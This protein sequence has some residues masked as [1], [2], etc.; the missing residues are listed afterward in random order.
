MDGKK[1]F[2][3]K[4][5]PENGLIIEFWKGD[6]SLKEIIVKQKLKIFKLLLLLIYNLK[7]LSQ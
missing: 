1:K 4:I 5:L 6:F 2:K 3:Y 7:F